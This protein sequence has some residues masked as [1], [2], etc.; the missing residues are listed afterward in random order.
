M[1]S[2]LCLFE[3]VCT[4]A[5]DGYYRMKEHAGVDAAAPRAGSRER[6]GQ[7]P[8]CQARIVGHG[9]HRGRAFGCRT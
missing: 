9:Q 3:G 8:Q 5:A 1:R 4:G 7:Y 6:P 2:V